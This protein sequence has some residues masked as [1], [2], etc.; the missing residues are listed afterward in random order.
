MGKTLLPNFTKM[1]GLIVAIIQDY[2][3]NEVLMQAFMNEAAWRLTL[4]EG[5][6]Y[7]WSRRR[8]C[9]W[10]KG[11]TS[12]NIL[13]VCEM[14]LDCDYDSVLIKVKVEGD[15]LACHTGQRSCFFTTI[16]RS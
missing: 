12:G 7:F 13:T 10:F 15:G 11:E 3:T 14:T 4:V 6:V 2:Q 8:Q 16:P 1:A 5:R 9:L